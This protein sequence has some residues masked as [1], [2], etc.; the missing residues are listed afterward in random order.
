MSADDAPSY[1]TFNRVPTSYPRG[2]SYY[3][4]GDINTLEVIKAKLTDEQ[5]RGFLLGNVL[6]YSC[7]MMHK[8]D[9]PTSD[10]AKAA[11]YARWLDEHINVNQG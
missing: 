9:S 6:K 11:T 10:A 3:D 1:R 2:S 7:R 5:Y 8:N 4:A